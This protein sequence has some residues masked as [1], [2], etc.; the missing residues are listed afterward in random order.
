MEEKV[1]NEERINNQSK[2][3]LRSSTA[4]TFSGGNK[5]GSGKSFHTRVMV[6]GYRAVGID[7]AIF[8]GDGGNSDVAKF[9]DLK[10]SFNLNTSEGFSYL[11]DSI[12]SSP[13][14]KP[15][16][17]SLPGGADEK[18]KEHSPGFFDALADLA[19]ATNRVVQMHWVIDGNR[20]GL[21]S[22]R[23]FRIAHP[24][25]PIDVIRNLFFGPPSAFS[26]F[27]K[28]KERESIIKNGGRIIDLP[29]LTG[30]VARE[31]L[32]HRWTHTVALK[33]LGFLD[34]RELLFWWNATL[35]N[36]RSGGVLP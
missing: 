4:I 7:P 13:V 3:K 25:I 18:S 27:D 20:D 34:R 22:L 8:E 2:A 12:E 16:V 11:F 21:E 26:F 6:E 23:L 1:Q 28:S 36:Y 33:E 15:V 9:Y 5:G 24:D 10:S 31:V 29:V 32:T 30:R 35:A 17:I 19:K 14:D